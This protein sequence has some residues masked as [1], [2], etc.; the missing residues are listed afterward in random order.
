MARHF[1]ED[2][3]GR[4]HKSVKGFTREAEGLFLEYKWPGNVRELK[5]TIERILILEDSDTIAPEH[6]PP[7]IL[8][9]RSLEEDGVWIPQEPEILR[10][11]SFDS[12]LDEI[13]RYM[14]REALRL[15]GGNKA[16]AARSLDMDRGTL[17]Y[18]IKRLE[19]ERE[20]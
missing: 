13:A 8:R 15:A 2:A 12:V 1:I 11:V 3:N 5:N 16:Q 9:G 14:I 7:E 6:L 18:Q 20:E 17:R 4:F 19:L 10:G